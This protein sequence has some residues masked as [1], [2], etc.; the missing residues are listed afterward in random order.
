MIKSRLAFE[1]IRDQKHA[2]YIYSFFLKIP[3]AKYEDVAICSRN[4]LCKLDE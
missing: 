2:A 4:T 1:A 3:F